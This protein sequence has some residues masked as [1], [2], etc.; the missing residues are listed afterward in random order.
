[1]NAVMKDPDL[2]RAMHVLAERLPDDATWRDVE[3]Y[4]RLRKAATEGKEAIFRGEI[5]SGDYV[6]R[7]FA[8][9]GVNL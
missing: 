2:R 6:R 4:A 9:Y 5:A 7:V 3:E 8:K 1:M